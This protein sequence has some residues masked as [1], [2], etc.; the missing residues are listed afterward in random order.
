M[1]KMNKMRFCFDTGGI[2]PEEDPRGHI[3]FENVFF[4]YPTRCHVPILEDLNL[5]ISEGSITAIVGASG[6]GKSTIASILLRLYDP[7]S[8]VIKL[9]GI[10]ISKLD[11]Q[12]MR[13]QIGYV[14]Q[15]PVSPSVST[16]TLSPF[17]KITLNFRNRFC[18]PAPSGTIFCMGQRIL[19]L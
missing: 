2:I 18:S 4:S 11:P 17:V 10:D 8:G 14:G 12:W 5:E 9:D 15:V 19:G 16:S 1:G 3:I 13:Q 6:S 7:N